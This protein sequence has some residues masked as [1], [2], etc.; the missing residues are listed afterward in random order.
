MSDP[1]G[2]W[3]TDRKPPWVI[4]Y[5]NAHGMM[6]PNIPDQFDLSDP[7]HQYP[8][9]EI[10]SVPGNGYVQGF[11]SILK[12]E[13]LPK[14]RSNWHNLGVDMVLP[15]VLRSAAVESMESMKSRGAAVPVDVAQTVFVNAQEKMKQLYHLA[16]L[17]D[18]LSGAGGFSRLARPY[19]NHFF[20]F[21]QNEDEVKRD[22]AITSADQRQV[23]QLPKRQSAHDEVHSNPEAYGWWIVSTNIG[24]LKYLSLDAISDD[25]IQGYEIN[26][27]KSKE[28]FLPPEKIQSINMVSR[29][30]T[31]PLGASYW[32][33]TIDRLDMT[34]IDN[35]E[36][37]KAR[38]LM[39][40]G[41]LWRTRVSS[42]HEILQIF[43]VINLKGLQS[44]VGPLHLKILSTTCRIIDPDLRFRNPQ[45]YHELVQHFPPPCPAPVKPQKLGWCQWFRERFL[46]KQISRYSAAQALAEDSENIAEEAAAGYALDYASARAVKDQAAVAAEGSTSKRSKPGGGTK[47]KRSKYT[48]KPRTRKRK[49]TQR[50][51]YRR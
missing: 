41:N 1:H 30:G 34:G 25:A 16:G 47:R 2:S 42:L 44:G 12:K 48:R 35:G 38:S 19:D 27:D 33:N 3:T 22:R 40:I 37:E 51:R 9:L 49:Y 43:K 23:R 39:A 32:I 13:S 20:Q 26:T 8:T 24:I 17:Y 45:I 11:M 14:E 36:V 31:Q 50:R 6:N 7:V 28:P 4:A 18:E 29:R 46:P 10:F 15:T 5:F 21:F